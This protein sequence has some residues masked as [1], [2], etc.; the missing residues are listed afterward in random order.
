MNVEKP[1]NRY[2]PRSG[3]RVAEDSLTSY[4]GFIVGFCNTNC[5]DDFQANITRRPNDTIYFDVVI[6]ELELKTFAQTS[7]KYDITGS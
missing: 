1:I 4:R 5:R 6:K 3:K 2:C 7:E